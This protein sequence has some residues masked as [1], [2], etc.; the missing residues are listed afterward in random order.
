MHIFSTALIWIYWIAFSMLGGI[1]G[2][3]IPF[4]TTGI[5]FALT[6][7][8]IVIL[9]EQ[10]KGAESVLPAVIAAAASVLMII[11]FGSDSFLLPALMLTVTILVLLRP[12]LEKKEAE[13]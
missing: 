3:L 2:S 12:R 4:D 1:V 9:I 11:L 5:D 7:L 10:M 6:A 13:T 8:F